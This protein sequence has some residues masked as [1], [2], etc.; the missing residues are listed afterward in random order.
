M[1]LYRSRT[2]LYNIFC[3]NR[4]QSLENTYTALDDHSDWKSDPFYK[5]SNIQSYG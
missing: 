4:N 1:G 2:Y 5:G 3:N